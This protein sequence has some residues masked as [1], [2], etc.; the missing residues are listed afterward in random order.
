MIQ[1]P[2][3]LIAFSNPSAVLTSEAD[4][5]VSAEDC[6]ASG[7]IEGDGVGEGLT[8]GEGEGLAGVFGVVAQPLSKAAAR[9]TQRNNA[10]RADRVFIFVLLRNG[11]TSVFPAVRNFMYA[12]TKENKK[13]NKRMPLTFN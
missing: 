13:I 1:V 10:D 3:S 5:T 6:E 11:F 8:T 12:P 4:E 9:V 2:F 7:D